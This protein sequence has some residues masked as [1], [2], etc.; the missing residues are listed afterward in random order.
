MPFLTD[1]T[2]GAPTR[3]HLE[4]LFFVLLPF[5]E[6]D[7]LYH[8]F[9]PANP[10]SYN[11]DSATN[12]GVTSH[13]LSLYLCQSDA[14]TALDATY[15]AQGKV[16]PPP[17]PPFL[18]LYIGRYAC[19]NYAANGLVFGSNS[20]RLPATFA[21]GLS[22][23]VLLAEHFRYCSGTAFLWGYGGNGNVNPSFAFL[24]LPGG[25][26][27]GMFA[28][29]VPLHTDANGLVYG[30]VGQGGPCPGTVTKPVAFQVTPL[31]SHCDPSLPQTA[32]PAGM[33][34]ALGD[35]SV[36]TVAGG[37]SEYTFWAAC[38]PS[39]QEALGADW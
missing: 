16:I 32:H 26:A 28:P 17:P 36:R 19:T 5:V 34:V 30:K 11:R 14:S 33:Q 8:A 9:D 37:M 24:S 29:D 10:T 27:T 15:Q 6:Q 38:T 35:G 3:A 12:P 7:N 39:G 21:D 18:S 25:T 31:A 23:T 4:S 13:V 2:P 22:N 20:A 1:T